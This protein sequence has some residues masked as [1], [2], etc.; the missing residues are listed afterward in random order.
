METNS[1]HDT[2]TLSAIPNGDVIC[3]Y[4]L[5]KNKTYIPRLL[6]YQ[7]VLR[8]F[9]L[10]T[11]EVIIMATVWYQSHIHSSPTVYPLD[12]IYTHINNYL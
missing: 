10:P 8:L 1:E 12:S 2:F 3:K 7:Y 9:F 11:G 6:E 5:I 4:S